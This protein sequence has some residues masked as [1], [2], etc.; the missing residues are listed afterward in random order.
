[1]AL[2]RLSEPLALWA[3]YATHL[4]AAGIVD[5]AAFIELAPWL[6]R[7]VPPPG[8]AATVGYYLGWIAWL[9]RPPGINRAWTLL[10]IVICATSIVAGPVRLKKD[11]DGCGEL[12]SPL[13]IH[14]LDVNQA[15]ATFVRLPTG[16]TL[17]VD[18]GGQ[19]GGRLDVGGRIIAPILWRFGVGRLDYLAI[20]HGDP[21]HIGGAAS[22]VEDFRPLEVWEGVPVPGLPVLDRLVQLASGRGA[23]WRQLQKGDALRS[24]DVRIY[25]WHPPRPDWER[26]RVRND[27]SLVLEIRYRDVSVVL[28]GDIGSEVEM[29]LV[30]QIRPA[31]YR[32]LK[33]PH[34]GSRTSSS[35]GFLDALRPDVAVVSAGHHN[36][37]GHPAREVVDRYSRIGAQLISTAEDGAVSVCTDGA[38]VVFKT[39]GP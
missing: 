34:H 14:V 4:A 21:D 19:P 30:G 17:L 22:V 11:I 20:T 10:G 38:A 35:A 15:D 33:V 28:P 39:V 13:S 8:V 31:G 37:F 16:R 6:T 32:I 27:D 26:P 2:L 23:S 18:A 3:G 1:M 5:S 12:E 25:V 7:R 36:R 29:T 24:G 9:A